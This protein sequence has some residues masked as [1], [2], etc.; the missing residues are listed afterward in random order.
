M[1][2]KDLFYIDDDLNL[3]NVTKKAK[4]ISIIV[5]LTGA[6]F[7]FMLGTTVVPNEVD[8]ERETLI[9]LLDSIDEVELTPVELY[10]YLKEINIKF[11]EIVFAQAML[12]TGNLISKIYKQGNN[13]FGMKTAYQRPTTSIETG[14]G[15]AIYEN[16]KESVI[17]YSFYQIKYLG[18]IKTE[19]EYLHYLSKNYAEDPNYIKKLKYIVNN[20]DKYLY[21]DK[22]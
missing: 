8:I 7:G 17:D 13:L 14:H 1:K 19:K 6:L 4:Q 5:L 2:R 12:E 21:P 20:I 10:S 16:W 3:R 15:H 11:P 18:K 22:G 9:V